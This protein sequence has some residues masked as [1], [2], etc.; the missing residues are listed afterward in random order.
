MK[1][2]KVITALLSVGCLAAVFMSNVETIDTTLKTS[3]SA[4][5]SLKGD[6]SGNGKI[7]LYDAIEISKY[8]MGLRTLT[9]TQEIIA[10]YNYDGSVNLYDA[11]AIS[12]HIM[13][14]K[15]AVPSVVYY[16]KTGKCYHYSNTCNGGTY[17]AC[18]YN[19]AIKK[20]LKPCNKCVN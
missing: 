7:D 19:E 6:L 4:A 11:I 12:K 10:D 2:K 15:P 8:I 18:T 16:T 9:H 14:S 3:I 20:G 5:R 13:D 1:I 17:Y